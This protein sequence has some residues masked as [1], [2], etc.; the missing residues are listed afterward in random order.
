MLA[1]SS[2]YPSGSLLASGQIHPL[3][4]LAVS[5]AIAPHG[6][7]LTFVRSLP[8]LWSLRSSFR[9]HPNGL[10]R[11]ARGGVGCYG[12]AKR[13]DKRGKD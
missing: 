9:L 3:A 4:S 6:L 1:H 7:P 11:F 13:G 8:P 12:L 2:R 5:V 10:A